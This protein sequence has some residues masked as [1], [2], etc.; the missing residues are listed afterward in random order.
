MYDWSVWHPRPSLYILKQSITYLG[1]VQGFRYSLSVVHTPHNKKFLISLPTSLLRLSSRFCGFITAVFN[2][3]H[4][5][6][7]S[8]ILLQSMPVMSV[9]SATFQGNCFQRRRRRH[10]DLLDI[11]YKY[12]N[13]FVKMKRDKGNFKSYYPYRMRGRQLV[14]K[15]KSRNVVFLH[16]S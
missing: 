12:R 8:I 1:V 10:Y 3:P 11:Q 2:F 5:R 9:I 14:A 16:R 4:F 15:V 13:M 6:K 7:A